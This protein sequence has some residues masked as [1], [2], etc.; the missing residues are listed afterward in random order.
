M[1]AKNVDKKEGVAR[2][3]LGIILL[4]LMFWIEG[5]KRL[6]FGIIGLSLIGTAFVGT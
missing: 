2:V 1:F 4:A 3:V 6:I 5:W